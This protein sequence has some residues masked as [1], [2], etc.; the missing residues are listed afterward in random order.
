MSNNNV[1]DLSELTAT[2]FKLSSS[3]M[4]QMLCM[5]NNYP[6]DLT[7]LTATRPLNQFVHDMPAGAVHVEQQPERPE[8]AHGDYL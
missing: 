4:P 3:C 7:E 2:S 1:K 6:K 5:T 8:Q